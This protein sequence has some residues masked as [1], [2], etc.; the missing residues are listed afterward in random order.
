[1]S[2]AKIISQVVPLKIALWNFLYSVHFFQ[3]TKW[4]KLTATVIVKVITV[5]PSRLGWSVTMQLISLKVV[6][7]AGLYIVYN[8]L[9]GTQVQMCSCTA[10]HFQVAGSRKTVGHYIIEYSAKF[11]LCAGDFSHSCKSHKFS[12]IDSLMERNSRWQQVMLK[13]S[14]FN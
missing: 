7:N 4:H 11:V 10:N 1:M 5:S 13:F 12:L 2:N 9:M 3:P 6:K 14:C 8:F